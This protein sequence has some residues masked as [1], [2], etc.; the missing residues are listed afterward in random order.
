MNNGAAWREPVFGVGKKAKGG[1]LG[2][3]SRSPATNSTVYS[4]LARWFCR[5]RFIPY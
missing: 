5:Q 2:Q 4:A 1:R 3:A